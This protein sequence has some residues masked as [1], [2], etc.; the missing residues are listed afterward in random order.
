MK[1]IL[2]NDDV[3]PFIV[4]ELKLEGFDAAGQQRTHGTGPTLTV[5][6]ASTWD[7]QE[8]VRETVK[9]RDPS[10]N[11]IYDEQE[12]DANGIHHV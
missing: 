3:V 8:A 6:N 9:R 2:S 5:R 1:F 11:E 10:A 7:R 4:D 12:G